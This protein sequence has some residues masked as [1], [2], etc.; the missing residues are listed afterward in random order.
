LVALDH[1]YS[2]N[3]E[4]FNNNLAFLIIRAPDL[5]VNEFCSGWLGGDS[6]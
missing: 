6:S 3:F 2:G 4:L 5:S 1:R